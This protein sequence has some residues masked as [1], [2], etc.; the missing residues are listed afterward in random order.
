MSFLSNTLKKTGIIFIVGLIITTVWWIHSQKTKRSANI[1]ISSCEGKEY[2]SSIVDPDQINFITPIGSI[3][4]PG[5]I[6]PV[7]QVYFNLVYSNR[8]MP[9]VD[10]HAPGNIAITRIGSHEDSLPGVGKVREFFLY[11]S[12]CKDIQ[13]YIDHFDDLNANL[14][15]LIDYQYGCN[16]GPNFKYC[17]TVLKKPYPVKNGDT[18]GVVGKLRAKSLDFATYDLRVQNKFA[19]ASRYNKR[20]THVVCPLDYY[21]EGS[22]KDQLVSKLKRNVKPLCGQLN[23]D[24]LGTLQGAWFAGSAKAFMP[25]A[26]KKQLAFLYDNFK[27]Q[28]AVISIGGGFTE[29]STYKFI[30]QTSGTINRRF[31]QIKPDLNIYCFES[32]D[33]E[34]RILVQMTSFTEINIEK[35]TGKCSNNVALRTPSVYTR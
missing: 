24:I 31:N 13:G 9:L 26:G 20:S 29:A 32:K 19:N 30:P 7:E 11:F 27:P 35:Q 17:E 1:N 18:I 23:Y 14:K 16:E 4:P 3:A 28:K 25:N 15:N 22:I 6:L 34:E 12:L 8:K 33:K 5:H 2:K 10:V 21:P